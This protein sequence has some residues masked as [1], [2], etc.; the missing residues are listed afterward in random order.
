MTEVVLIRHGESIDNVNGVWSGKSNCHLTENGILSAQKLGKKLKNDF[1]LIYC[2]AL[3]RTKETIQALFPN[4]QVIYDK[5]IEEIS[6]GDWEQKKKI[7]YD[8][9]L[10]HLFREGIY[11]PPNGEKH[12]D[13][14][15]R[16]T[17]FIEEL[18]ETKKDKKILV[19]THNGV[20]RSIKRNFKKDYKE[21]MSKNLEIL[22]L[23]EKD[24]IY[25][26]NHKDNDLENIMKTMDLIEYGYKDKNNKN[27]ILN[28]KY[29]ETNFANFYK[30]LSPEELITKKCGVC[31]DQVE[32]ERVLF[33][34]KNINTETFFIYLDDKKNLPSHTF[35]VFYQNNKVFWFEHSWYNE[36]G[37]HEYSTLKEL[38]KDV[39]EKFIKSRQDE[40]PINTKVYIYK[41]KKP[42]YNLTCNEFY[43]YIFN[44]KEVGE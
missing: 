2:S 8:S 36:K 33:E 32:L 14:D 24:Y 12:K 28:E 40:V 16:V 21:L 15:N 1:D 35:L 6:L 20:L 23:S 43:D 18:F 39:K 19:I 4:T 37:I 44:E 41:Y 13:L 31:W 29:F 30:L 3:T 11:S 17:S 9:T 34:T 38:L 42:P 22:T 26:K 7:N 5:R 25:Y 10:K 27:L